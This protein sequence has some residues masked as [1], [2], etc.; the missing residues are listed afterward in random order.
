[1]YRYTKAIKTNNL[2]VELIWIV[3]ACK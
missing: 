1:M 3:E 2:K